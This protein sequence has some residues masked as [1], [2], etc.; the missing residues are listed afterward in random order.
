MNE[1]KAIAWFGILSFPVKVIFLYSVGEYYQNERISTQVINLKQCTIKTC[2]LANLDSSIITGSYL[3]A[4]QRKNRVLFTELI[5]K[6]V[7]R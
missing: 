7:N 4:N 5:K 2:K 3:D 6:T 1:V